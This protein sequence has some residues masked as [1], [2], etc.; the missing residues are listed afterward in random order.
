MRPAEDPIAA[1]VRL[2]AKPG[3]AGDLHDLLIQMAAVAA[4]DEGTQIWAVHRGR[5][6]S[7]EFFLYELY[8]DR[9]AF[10]MHQRNDELNSLGR[11]MRELTGELVVTPGRLV[12]GLRPGPSPSSS[13]R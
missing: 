4:R 3:R 11:R 12:G 1:C 8:R 10:D 13:E 7:G 9:A 5:R 2:V 6:E